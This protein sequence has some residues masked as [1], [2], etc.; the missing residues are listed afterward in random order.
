MPLL[1]TLG[2]ALARTVEMDFVFGLTALAAL[3]LVVWFWVMSSF[4]AP[5]ESEGL[6]DAAEDEAAAIADGPRSDPVVRR[7]QRVRAGQA[8]ARQH[9][10]SLARADDAAAVLPV[11]RRLLVRTGAGPMRVTVSGSMPS[12]APFCLLTVSNPGADTHACY[13]PF[14]ASAAAAIPALRRAAVVSIDLPGQESHAE[15]FEPEGGLERAPL[16]DAPP[17]VS[18]SSLAEAVVDCCAAVRP[19]VPGIG[20]PLC[21]GSPPPSDTDALAP[22]LS[23]LFGDKGLGGA[24]SHMDAPGGPLSASEVP[25]RTIRPLKCLLL[26]FG[27]AVDD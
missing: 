27:I 2:N 18:F 9:D 23:K 1:S 7:T 17:L 5:L 8:A 11:V 24:C 20:I 22:R 3:S 13:G 16:P 4:P 21:D 14:L 25:H 6:A 10:A 19:A 12:E 26:G 15:E